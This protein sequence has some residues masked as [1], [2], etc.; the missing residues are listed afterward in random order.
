M[1]EYKYGTYNDDRGNKTVLNKR[2]VV[3]ARSKSNKSIYKGRKA[4][5]ICENG[6]YFEK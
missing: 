5:D 4:I 2:Y 1:N 6:V 3:L